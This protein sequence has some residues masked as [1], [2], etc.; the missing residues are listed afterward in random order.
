MLSP[1]WASVW[2]AG[3]VPTAYNA[4]GVMKAAILMTDGEYNI[5]YQSPTARDQALALCDNMRAA[6]I[7]VYTVGFGFS[8]TSTRNDNTAEG[9]AKDLLMKCAGEQAGAYFFPYD[10][11][12]LRED[13]QAIG[14][15]LKAGLTVSKARLVN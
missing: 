4:Q 12:K 15:Q 9:K 11:A 3:S 13:F 5:H 7:K 8:T 10:G 6:G 1:K 14:A 2:P